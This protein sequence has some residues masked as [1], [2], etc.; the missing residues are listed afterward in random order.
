VEWLVYIRD[1]LL[2]FSC[3]RKYLSLVFGVRM[4][5]DTSAGGD[6]GQTQFRTWW[7]VLLTLAAYLLGVLR[8]TELSGIIVLLLRGPT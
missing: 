7:L 3:I 1:V 6:T 2:N 8:Y 5:S 4:V